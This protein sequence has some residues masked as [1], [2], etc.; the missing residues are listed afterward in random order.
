MQC[1]RDREFILQKW[2]QQLQKPFNQVFAFFDT[3]PNELLERLPICQVLA[4]K[5]SET[6]E[7]AGVKDSFA[8]FVEESMK[9]EVQNI[10][11]SGRDEPELQPVIPCCT[12]ELYYEYDYGDSWLVKI[13]AWEDREELIRSKRVT[14]D[15]VERA[16]STVCTEDRPVCIAADG[17]PVLDDVGGL[18]GYI[19]FL[20]G[21][22]REREWAYWAKRTAEEGG[23]K[24]EIIERIPDNWDYDEDDTIDWGWSQGW[25][26]RMNRPEKLL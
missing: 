7:N 25:T 13:T 8:A 6:G 22:N 20:R 14:A 2:L 10:L 4:I 18:G 15:E 23:T 9:D 11:E 5:D 26:G 1:T 19:R 24:E 16:V 12:D 21:I 3:V 17:L